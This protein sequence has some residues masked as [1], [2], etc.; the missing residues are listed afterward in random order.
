MKI[1]NIIFIAITVGVI[2]IDFI[3]GINRFKQERSVN[4]RRFESAAKRQYHSNRR[5]NEDFEELEQELANIGTIL[6][7]AWV[8]LVVFTVLI[9]LY[10]IA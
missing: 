2:T 6:L 5:R 8:K 10:A 1:L 4:K 7:G 9:F 3:K